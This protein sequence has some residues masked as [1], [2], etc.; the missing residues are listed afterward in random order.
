MRLRCKVKDARQFRYELFEKLDPFLIELEATIC[1]RTGDVS[2]GMSQARDKS[3][4]D[5]IGSICDDG[6]LCGRRFEGQCQRATKRGYHVGVC[7]DHFAGQFRMAVSSSL[8]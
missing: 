6:D 5:R 2:A 1:A 7:R 4:G 3:D 8:G